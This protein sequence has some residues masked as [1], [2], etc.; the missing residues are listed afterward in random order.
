MPKDNKPQSEP[1]KPL[2][3]QDDTN[4]VKNNPRM[5]DEPS[6]SPSQESGQRK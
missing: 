5:K 1:K 4:P 2:R 6:R 3:P